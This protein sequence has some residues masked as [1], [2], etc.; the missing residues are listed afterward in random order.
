MNQIDVTKMLLANYSS[1]KQA[2]ELSKELK[3]GF[4][5][6]YQLA[7]LAIGRSLGEFDYPPPAPD[8]RGLPIKGMQLFGNSGEE[9]L[10]IGL[11]VTNF[12]QHL[13]KAALTI[14]AIQTLVRD[15]WH[16][17]VGLL[18]EDWRE[19]EGRYEKFIDIL[20]V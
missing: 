12:K 17:G 5:A 1:S 11:L 3:L 10:W 13:P 4:Q 14:D 18:L 2:D 8:V 9:L 20:I 7:R 19:A 15:H 6:R 16:R